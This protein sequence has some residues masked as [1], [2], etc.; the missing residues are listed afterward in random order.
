MKKFIQH[1]SVMVALAAVTSSQAQ[2]FSLEDQV[3]H[4][5]VDYESSLFEADN[6]NSNAD[7]NPGGLDDLFGENPNDG[8][9]APINDYVP[10]L[11]IGAAG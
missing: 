10:F 2:I 9:P 5:E 4:T 3:N 8:D 7:T 6:S 11:L 1:I